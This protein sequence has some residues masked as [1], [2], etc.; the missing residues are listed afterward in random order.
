M[1]LFVFL[2]IVLFWKSFR[3]IQNILIYVIVSF[4]PGVIED[5]KKLQE[6]DLGSRCLLDGNEKVKTECA[7]WEDSQAGRLW[8][9]ALNHVAA[10]EVSTAET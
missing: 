1:Y 2:L 6:S 4:I 5:K 3:V 9:P 10:A 8:K 7:T